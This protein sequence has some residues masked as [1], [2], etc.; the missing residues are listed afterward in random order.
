MSIS[1][2]SFEIRLVILLTILLPWQ[3]THAQDIN[4]HQLNFDFQD[5]VYF[6]LEEFKSNRPK[7]E[8]D[9]NVLGNTKN[10][11]VF[12]LKQ[13]R[14]NKDDSAYVISAGKVMFICFDGK[15][16]INHK[17]ARS[18]DENNGYSHFYKIQ[19]TG[20]F[21]NYF[22]HNYSDKAYLSAKK[23]EVFTNLFI[24]SFSMQVNGLKSATPDQEY[25][26]SL[27]DDKV[28]NVKLSAKK[29]K[30]LIKE[31]QYFSNAKISNKELVIYLGQYN[32][33]NIFKFGKD[34]L[35]NHSD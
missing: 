25:I 4:N 8:L 32:R 17:Y 23:A 21:C 18:L 24:P 11:N 10:N 28:Y 19:R 15:I 33:R 9:T 14:F 1:E 29:L 34:W 27:K 16:F 22:R 31:D 26:L 13:I 3:W 30:A 20:Y 35:V 5:G 12:K 6:D 2:K 7:I